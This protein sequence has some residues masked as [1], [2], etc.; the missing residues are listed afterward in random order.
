[1]PCH[2]GISVHILALTI[3]LSVHLGE[4]EIEVSS[5]GIYDG[6]S[7][8][9]RYF[10]VFRFQVKFKSLLWEHISVVIAAFIPCS[11]ALSD[12]LEGLALKN[13]SGC[14]LP[15]PP[16][17][18]TSSSTIGCHA[19]KSHKGPVCFYFSGPRS[20]WQIDYLSLS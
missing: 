8:S 10:F 12:V 18:S 14:K 7:T 17:F 1:M 4:I 6:K 9:H 19:G 16:S 5:T 13:F 3:L 11:R 20:F 15:R 2:I